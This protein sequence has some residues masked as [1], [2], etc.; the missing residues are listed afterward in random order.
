MFVYSSRFVLYSMS[1]PMS[2]RTCVIL[3]NSQAICSASNIWL[4]YKEIRFFYL[5]EVENFINRINSG[6]TGRHVV[7]RCYLSSRIYI[8]SGYQM[9]RYGMKLTPRGFRFYKYINTLGLTELLSLKVHILDFRKYFKATLTLKQWIF[10]LWFVYRSYANVTK[11]F[12]RLSQILWW[13]DVS[14]PRR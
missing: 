8:G 6:K 5:L 10:L 7:D 4:Y 2:G 11:V 12:S 14:D 9:P 3:I 13:P 1:G